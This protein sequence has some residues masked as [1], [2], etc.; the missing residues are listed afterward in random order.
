MPLFNPTG[1]YAS[2]VVP[3]AF[4]LILQQTLLIG[5][6]MLGGVAFESGGSMAQRRAAG[7]AV[8]GAGFAHL[9]HLSSGAAAVS[10][11]SAAGLR[12]LDAGTDCRIC[13]S[14]P[15]RSCSRPASSA[16]PPAAWFKHRETAVVLFVATTLPQFF[17][18]GVS[19][20]VEAIPPALR[21]IGRIFPSESAIDGLVRINQMGASLG[22]VRADWIYLWLLTAVYF[23]LAL[24]ASR[25][26]ASMR[27]QMPPSNRA[28]LA[29][30]RGAAGGRGGS[31][32][33]CVFGSGLGTV[34]APRPPGVVQATEIKIAPEISGR[35]AAL[36]GRF[37]TE[38]ARGRCPRP[39]LEPRARSRAGAGRGAIGAGARRSRSGLRRSAAGAGR[40][41]RAR[42]R[43]GERQSDLRRQQFARSS[44]LAAAGFAS[45]Q[46]LDKATD[47]G[48]HGERQCSARKGTIPRPPISGR[49]ARNA[50]S[51]TPGSRRGRSGC[52]WSPARVAKLQIRAPVDGIVAL[53]VAEPGEAIVPGQPVMTC[54]PAGRRWAS[55]NMREDQFTSL[56]IG[57]AVEPDGGRRQRP[58]STAKVTEIMPRGEF[59]TW[60]AARAV[61]D[62]DLNTF[63]LRVDSDEPTSALQP[64]MTVWLHP[65]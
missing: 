31:R 58:A 17:L 60:R 57:S 6:A 44:Q 51:P 14:S 56:R 40:R 62:H 1:G 12:L 53:L 23:V 11:D 24:A 8:L 27:P 38:C 2:Y 52:A 42:H 29:H 26:R 25:R 61:G 37:G 15:R 20:P 63:Q 54:R 13:R 65:P 4:V 50:Q 30:D 9:T 35:L 10:R 48:R 47:G 5:A 45:H 43:H 39:A 36:R 34:P 16:R 33:S 64:G 21:L 55:F 46:D 22:E 49:T 28:A 32:H 41:A 18:V 19:W 59:A 3:A 7:R